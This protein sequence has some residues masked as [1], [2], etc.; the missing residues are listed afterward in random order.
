V[1]LLSHLSLFDVFSTTAPF[2][3]YFPVLFQRLS[4]LA[5][6]WIA[7]EACRSY[8]LHIYSHHFHG[9]SDANLACLLPVYPVFDSGLI[10]YCPHA[11]SQ[12]LPDY[13]ASG[14]EKFTPEFL[15]LLSSIYSFA[16]SIT[17]E[18]RQPIGR[19]AASSPSL[20][21]I[22]LGVDASHL[23]CLCSIVHLKRHIP[24]L[25]TTL[26]VL[27]YILKQSCGYLYDFMSFYT[28]PEVL[29]DILFL[30]APISKPPLPNE[31][32]SSIYRYISDVDPTLLSYLLLP[33]FRTV[34]LKSFDYI[35]ADLFNTYRSRRWLYRSLSRLLSLLAVTP[36]CPADILEALGK[37]PFRTAKRLARLRDPSISS[38]YLM[39]ALGTSFGS[40]APDTV[41]FY[42]VAALLH[43]NFP[44]DALS[45]LLSTSP[46]CADDFMS[47]LETA[48]QRVL[49]G[50]VDPGLTDLATAC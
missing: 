20:Q 39:Q 45:L 49:S 50:S 14:G 24:G 44:M 12:W 9:Y 19:S 16:L 31:T 17:R 11:T 32:F 8:S 7:P 47:A 25:L 3:S 41:S 48:R 4:S 1:F 38:S 22:L 37:S 10:G 15:P 5:I 18:Y 33:W 28:Y 46:L 36:D 42:W 43:P 35:L 2:D 30:I 27:D 13:L 34:P 40:V 23:L 21:A 6:P 26:V 29:A